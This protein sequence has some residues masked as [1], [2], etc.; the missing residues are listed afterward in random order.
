MIFV[1]VITTIVLIL[2]GLLKRKSKI[3]AIIQNVWIWIVMGF[4]NGG[5][6][7][8]DNEAIYQYA[9]KELK[10]SIDSFN[11]SF[12]AYYAQKIGLQY[13][14]YNA[15]LVCLCL[16][17]LY[18]VVI[19]STSNI[20]MFYSLFLVYPFIDSV[21]QK[22]F[23]IA[24]IFCVLALFYQKT[25]NIKKSIISIII[26]IGFHFSAIVML[27]FLFLD[28]ILH[29]HFKIIWI[30]LIFEFYILYFH[31]NLFL[32]LSGDFSSKTLVYL[33]DNITILAAL[34]FVSIQFVL[35][36]LT[37]RIT[38]PRKNKLQMTNK[39][40]IIRINIFSLVF[41]PLL[42]MESTFFRYYRIIMILS[43]LEIINN[44]SGRFLK[45]RTRY[46]LVWIYIFVI[47][48]FQCIVISAGDYELEYYLLSLFK[49][50]KIL[51][52]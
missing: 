20:S 11:N 30:I 25:N 37:I 2:S 4:N 34:F 15:I 22:R 48:L 38:E 39:D 9:G 23:F 10:F 19:K 18:G 21:F 27:P 31:R 49:Y 36:Y 32:T 28:C 24:F 43:Y 45:N 1:G 52:G 3:L 6:D 46:Y 40:Y 5:L 44:F 29:N 17:L 51:G 33:T 42:T 14:Q 47:V 16:L 26:A 7:Y 12:L 50:N 13:W 8:I 41:L 35:V